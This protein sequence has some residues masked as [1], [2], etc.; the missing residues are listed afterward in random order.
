MKDNHFDYYA[1]GYDKILKDLVSFFD[2][3]ID[4]FAAYKV[5]Q[6]RNA[7]KT[8]HLK[9]LEYGCGTG[10]NLKYLQKRFPIAKIYGCDISE[11]SLI[12]AAKESPHA[13]IFS[14]AGNRSIGKFDLILISC[15][16]HHIP[17]I[18]QL[19]VLQEIYNLLNENGNIFIFEHNPYNP[20]TVHIVKKCPIGW[21]A[22]FIKPK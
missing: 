6:V 20:V 3:D 7:I 15:V 21:D 19:P 13:V 5:D 22:V 10:R 12:I 16:F 18:Q 1:E 14:T 8:D 4:H 11:K 2:G 17:S 9:I